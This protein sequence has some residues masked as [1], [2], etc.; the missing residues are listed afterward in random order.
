MA[1]NWPKSGVFVGEHLSGLPLQGFKDLQELFEAAFVHGFEKRTAFLRGNMFPGEGILLQRLE[2]MSA[3]G[4]LLQ[5]KED[6]S[7]EL[8]F[9]FHL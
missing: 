4:V 3:G 5:V 6:E 8:V 9:K 2:Q 1:T 7:M